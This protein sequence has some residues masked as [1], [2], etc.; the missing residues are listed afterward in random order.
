MLLTPYANIFSFEKE[1]FESD[2]FYKN[3]IGIGESSIIKI[4][5][6][7]DGFSEELE[8]SIPENEAL[9]LLE[10]DLE[11]V[12]DVS[13]DQHVWDSVNHWTSS[14]AE[15]ENVD[16]NL[17]GLRINSPAPSWDF[18]LFNHG[19]SL[20]AA[21]GWAWGVDSAGS[22]G[23]SKAIYTYQGQYPNQMSNT[24]YAT[25][26]SIDCSSCSGG[27]NVNFWKQLGVESSSWDHAY[28][29]VKGPNG[30]STLWQNSGSV[31]DSSYSL[32]SYRV[33]SYVAG[34]SDFRIRFGLGPTDFSV[35]YDG[36]NIDDV[37]ITP[38]SGSGNGAAKVEGSGDA[39]WTT[40]EIGYGSH[41]SVRAGP[42]G[43]LNILAETPE[44]TG[45]DWSV[46]DVQTNQAIPGYEKRTELFADLGRIDWILHPSIKIKVHLWSDDPSSPI[47]H[48]ISVG[49]YWETEFYQNPN[50][51]G[52]IGNGN[53]NSGN[54]QGSGNLTMSTI[55]STR[56]IKSI[57]NDVDVSGNGQLQISADN[58]NW[59]NVPS[60]GTYLLE[61]P[62]KQISFQWVSN[63]GTWTFNSINIE[64]ES[65]LYPL[66]PK[67]DIRKDGKDEWNLSRAE[68]GF[69]GS[70]DRWADGSISQ[71]VT[72]STASPKYI[73][74]WIP[75]DEVMGV[76]MDLTPESGEI[77]ELDVELRLGQSIIYDTTINN[78]LGIFRFCLNEIELINLNENITSN[79]NVWSTYGQSFV[80]AKLKL[81]GNAQRVW[82]SA[83][84]IPYNPSIQFREY[85]NSQIVNSIN[86]YLANSNII[87][88][89]Y[90]VPIPLYSGVKSSYEF[91]LLDQHST[92][93]LLTNDA[94]L[95]NATEPLVSSEKWLNLEAKHSVSFGVIESI[96][97]EM[98]SENNR[99]FLNFPTNGDPFTMSG[100]FN[101]IEL[102]N[103]PFSYTTI[104]HN[105]SKLIFRLNPI[106]DD[107]YNLEIKVRLVRNDGIKSIPDVIVFGN[108]LIKS[109]ENDIE[110]KSW[111]VR[112]DLGIKIPD[113]MP[114]LKSGSDVIIEIEIGFEDL[115]FI[116]NYP[117]SGDVE[118]F[119]L[120]NGFEIGRSSNLTNGKISFVRSIP[121]GPGNLTY[122]IKIEPLFNQSDATDIIVNRTFTADSLAPQLI[123]STVERYDHRSPSTNQ[124]LG[125]DIFDRP[126]LPD[127][128]QI[129]L[130][131]EW[132]DDFNQDGQPS[133]EEYW[134][135]TMFSPANLSTSEGRYT[136]VLD[137]SDA[138]LGDLVY[139]F[140]TGSDS[141]GN[142]LV[143]GGSSSIGDE[144]FIY[145]VKQDGS[146]QILSGDISWNQ[147]GVMW[148]NPDISYELN[149]PFNEPN[150][151]SDI[152]SITF[153][154]ADFSEIPGMRVYWD[155]S[156]SICN[157]TGNH[158]VIQ[159]CNIYSRSSYFGPF[160]NELEFRIKFKIK[161]SYLVEES[162]VHEPSIEIT[163][164]SGYN[165]VMTL[166]QLRWRF[167]S[168]IWVDADN[169]EISANIGTTID[170]SVYV[171]P[172]S[173]LSINGEISYSRTGNP[174]PTTTKIEISIGFNT[175]SNL[176]QNG[177]FVFEMNAP[178]SPGN[179]PLSISLPDLNSDI[180]DSSNMMTIWII[181]DNQP[182]VLEQVTSPRP[183]TVLTR[184]EI[185]DLIIELSIKETTKLVHDS[186]S[187]HWSVSLA[188]D[189]FVNYIIKDEIEISTLDDPISGRYSLSLLFPLDERMGELPTNKELSLNIWVEASDAAGNEISAEFNSL[190]S[191]LAS[192]IIQPLQPL[193]VISD[194]S[195]SKYGGI[196]IGDPLKVIISVENQGDADAITNLTVIVKNSG[197]EFIIAQ[198]PIS[199]LM[200]SKS[201]IALD[202]A[203]DTVGSQWIEVRWNEEYLG[204]GSL[205]SV[206]ESENSLFSSF[207][208]SG[209]IFAGIF[210][211]LIIVGTLLFILYNSDEEY[212]EEFEDYFE[213]EDNKKDITKM[214]IDLSLLPPLP[215]PPNIAPSVI[216]QKPVIE[217]PEIKQIE[218]RQ[219]TDEKGYTW[220]IIGD[221]PAQWW[222]G[223]TWADI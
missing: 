61:N 222:D 129:N 136:Y 128:L 90:N 69:W 50:E 86:D 40:P 42:Y 18:E 62:S 126:V 211:L 170:N 45:L 9:D 156:E 4:N 160:N 58:G 192:W 102:N 208:S 79:S 163:D 203:P 223:N 20:D 210:I 26:P 135:N 56:P 73:D 213:E 64:F 104:N 144:L 12:V 148:L 78:N 63:S 125:F 182:P 161:W 44:N 184:G 196:S 116:D 117:K 34:N 110:I 36:W 207:E 178:S 35:T 75:S 16:Y 198:E 165:T 149:L 99:I 53:W 131:R 60:I 179:Y 24:Y 162:V 10:F 107:D 14:W 31:S 52:W 153:D 100:D 180:F 89:N 28:F 93:G 124:I 190:S 67:I 46:I 173:L 120:E 91:S 189:I 150:G 97:Y 47:I 204:Q 84:D 123:S 157:S 147:S 1:E 166:P 159:S 88:G 57:S 83:L 21:G 151:I 66:S 48:S 119:V 82:I 197:G 137:D 199:I 171:L 158:I 155:S 219:W 186:I 118:V 85:T 96:E 77:V 27:W 220:R 92:S 181:V 70:Q 30:W 141:A 5:N 209:V 201:S 13:S 101:L 221:E 146:P 17:T 127:T 176:S 98:T 72:L 114:F 122:E 214:E 6:Y 212:Y 112:N 3:S 38:V 25:S 105:I 81:T 59:I 32:Q 142:M 216:P 103:N 200:N 134:S 19:W 205:V 43:M 139:G 8:L 74:F 15:Y 76:C 143:G 172:N 51:N 202:W 71:L 168:E 111:L 11:P 95:I 94:V 133:D 217:K 80:S 130:W 169:L 167:S 49:N 113:D 41:H 154:L 218:T 183:N 2:N 23:G 121:F 193:L 132:I 174:V 145:Q 177:L 185:P 138:S 108:D 33:D 106:W 37:S 39:N 191:P 115:T 206:T 194:I 164:R 22:H 55:H 215:P 68:I 87:N 195:Y 7:P 29:Q 65:G 54:Y 152:Q 175:N 140:V 187:I 188:D 109:V